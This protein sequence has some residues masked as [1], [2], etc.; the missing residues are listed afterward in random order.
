M[1]GTHRWYEYEF[2][3]PVF[4]NE[5]L[6]DGE[7]YSSFNEFEF[8]CTLVQGDEIN[9][10]LTQKNEGRFQASVNQLVHK[11][12]F[13]PPTKWLAKPKITRVQLIGFQLDE[14]ND[15]V[16]LVDRI[17]K[18]KSNVKSET[19]QAIQAAEK[20]NLEIAQKN[21]ELEKLRS[22]IAA[23]NQMIS[24]LSAK[25]GGLTEQR[26]SLLEDIATREKHISSLDERRTQIQE[27]ITER[28]SERE[29]L[30]KDV[31]NLRQE[32]RALKNDVD[33]FPTEISSFVSQGGKNISTYWKLATVPIGLLV[34]ISGLLIF[35]AANLTTVLDENRTANILSILLT[36]IPYVVIAMGI[37]T[38][39]YKLA[40]VCIVEIIRINKQRL[41][42]SKISIIATD[43]SN[44]SKDGLN[45]LTDRELYDLRTDLKMQ[46]LRDHLKEYLSDDFKYQAK[47]KNNWS[48]LLRDRKPS[49]LNSEKVEEPDKE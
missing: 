13:R 37:I 36:R 47:S 39:S 7:N 38:A 4:L 11:V 34:L 31:A 19:T 17:D 41:N 20:A 15:F 26:Q 27:K 2:I 16:R 8:R 5:I 40:K 28:T 10:I 45:D 14:L 24:E 9:K 22:D 32:L 33:M 25:I 46:M 3:K 21:N 29:A 23:E 12:S 49:T 42:L 1:D 30:A 6:V 18:Y 43:A 44:T 35:N 48:R